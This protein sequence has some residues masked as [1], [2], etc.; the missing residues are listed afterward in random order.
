MRS[1]EAL[2]LGEEVGF[3]LGQGLALGLGQA[4]VQVDYSP[5]T[6]GC[7]HQQGAPQAEPVF[8][9]DVGLGHDEDETVAASCR[10]PS[11]DTSASANGKENF[12]RCQC[13]LEEIGGNR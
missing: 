13:C 2:L 10:H 7:V 9:V 6:H 4:E 11:G 1:L 5:E 12:S 3:D 8:Q